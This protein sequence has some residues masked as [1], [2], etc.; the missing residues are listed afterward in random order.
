LLPEQQALPGEQ[1][2]AAPQHSERHRN[3]AKTPLAN[4]NLTTNQGRYPTG[5]DIAH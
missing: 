4:S 5:M 3:A 2:A 1:Q